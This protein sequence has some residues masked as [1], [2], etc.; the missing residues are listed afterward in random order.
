VSI[1]RTVLFISICNMFVKLAMNFAQS[2][3]GRRSGQHLYVVGL[4][5]TPHKGHIFTIWSPSQ[6]SSGS[7]C[8]SQLSSKQSVDFRKPRIPERFRLYAYSR[9]ESR[10]PLPTSAQVNFPLTHRSSMQRPASLAFV[11]TIESQ[12]KYL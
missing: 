10:P 2:S 8:C 7:N 4:S 11:I 9:L 6:T 1:K 3:R 5:Q 12:V